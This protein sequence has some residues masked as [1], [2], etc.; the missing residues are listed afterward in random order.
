MNN[1]TC[2]HG[3]TS[4]INLLKE[5]HYN[6]GGSGRHLCPTCAFE[7]GFIIGGSNN[8]KSYV[9]Y[10]R[11]LIDGESCPEKSIAPKS[12]LIRL[13]ENQGGSGRHKC[14]NCAFKQG[15]EARS[16]EHTSELQSRPHL[17]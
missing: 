8:W 16:E 11:T 7:E 14:T 4:P 3:G 13:G 2:I 10:C 6:Q 17:V 9:E 1:E 5:L 12:I 15:F